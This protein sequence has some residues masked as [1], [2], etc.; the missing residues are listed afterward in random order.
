MDNGYIINKTMLTEPCNYNMLYS[1]SKNNL[2][3]LTTNS[4]FIDI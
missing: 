4:S 3:A 2:T 1:S